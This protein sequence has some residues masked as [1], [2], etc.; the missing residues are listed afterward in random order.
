M[1]EKYL[2]IKNIKPTDIVFL[3]DIY[4][5]SVLKVSL[6]GVTCVFKSTHD[7]DSE[8]LER[9]IENCRSFPSHA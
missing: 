1:T 4:M 2:Q 7:V 3:E 6:K 9:E 8:Q 5:R